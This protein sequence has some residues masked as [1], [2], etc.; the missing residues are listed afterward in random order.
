MYGFQTNFV[1]YLWVRTHYDSFSVV[2]FVEKNQGNTKFRYVLIDT[3][4]PKQVQTR[5]CK[6]KSNG[7]LQK[8]KHFGNL[9]VA[10]A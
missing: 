9:L 10:H 3:C 1:R 6:L 5:K 2:T 7:V 4:Q 8:R